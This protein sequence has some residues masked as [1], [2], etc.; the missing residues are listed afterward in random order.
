[1]EGRDRDAAGRGGAQP[2][3]RVAV[4][5]LRYGPGSGFSIPSS[6][7][8]PR[9][10]LT[11]I[12]SLALREAELRTPFL[13]L[14]VAF[15][16]GICLYFAASGEPNL[17]YALGVALIFAL[18]ALALRRAPVWRGFFVAISAVAAGISAGAIRTQHVAAP[19]IERVMI[20]QVS[21]FVET[22]EQRDRDMR[23]VLRVEVLVG[24]EVVPRRV[25]VTVR[26]ESTI[27]PGDFVSARVRLVPPPEPS[28]P[29][30][31]DF[32]RES[33]FRGIG[34]VGSVLGPLQLAPPPGEPP[35]DIR[36]NAGI[37]AARNALTRRIADTIGGQA[38]AVA[39]ALVT[40][41]RGEIVDETNEA[42]RAAG[43]FHVVSISG[44]HMVLAAG[45]IFWLLRAVLA[46]SPAVALTWP[47]KKIA[48]IG[49]MIAAIAYCLFSGSEV[50]T[51]R[52]AIMT[53]VMFG[54]IL[55][56]RPALS[57]RNLAIA[58]LIVL[59]VR[60]ETLLGPS[61]QMSFAAV[62]ALIVYARTPIGL[63]G[64]PPP[65]SLVGRTIFGLRQSIVALVMTTLVATAATAPFGIFHFQVANPFGLIGNVLALP[66][67]SLIVM[68]CAVIGVFFYPLG[69]DAVFWQI[70][71][72]A[73]ESVLSLSAQMKTWDGARVVIPS[74]PL[75]AFVVLAGALLV[76]TLLGTSLR[77]LAGVPLLAG[78]A[79]AAAPVR[80]DIY[81]DREGI[82]AAVR[83]T[84]GRL[85]VLGRP[86]EFVREQWLTADGDGRDPSDP[87]LAQAVLCDRL[88]CTTTLK[89]GRSV[90]LVRDA[91]A[92]AEDCARAAIIISRLRAPE[93]C[94]AS[95]IIDR[96][97]LERHGAVTMHLAGD[98]TLV[99]T[100]S[101][102]DIERRAWEPKAPA[103]P[104]PPVGQPD[105][106]ADDADQ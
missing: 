25:R 86:S 70:M 60:P 17:V 21:G 24:A 5:K 100:P 74:I 92:F 18:A 30:G 88:G 102:R 40:G 10:A 19:A 104:S 14:P 37:D 69:L 23:M 90:A 68:P 26:G 12:R 67:V 50:A 96:N 32:R 61:F 28:R 66:F 38:G 79:L 7:V 34:A 95:T 87:S 62:A 45:A 49:A 82:G 56:D 84:D 35:L 53:L 29:G 105:Q 27:K 4:G 6:V 80:Q 48:A 47:V 65:T 63:R 73:V 54:A 77:L 3:A 83:G 43:I 1:M 72:L 85:V 89:D 13:W 15:G 8:D 39:A 57:L 98:G 97:L 81:V 31:Y 51:E 78:L 9:R 52:A 103:R 36:I 71:G 16:L 20:G 58:A 44:L 64:G 75:T 59:A 106:P 94:K 2:R 42:L 11:Q 41:K 76:A 101:R 99:L 33:F 91:A 22:L 93:T 55:I 46:L